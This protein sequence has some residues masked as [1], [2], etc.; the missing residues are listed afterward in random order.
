[1]EEANHRRK[2]T[3]AREG[4]VYNRAEHAAFVAILIKQFGQEYFE[5]VKGWGLAT[6][7]PVFVF[8]LPR[9][10]STLLEQ[11][12][13]SHPQVYGAGELALGKEAFDQVTRLLRCTELT[14][15]HMSLIS[16]ADVQQIA[17]AHLQ[18]LRRFSAG[19]MRIVDKMPDNY[20]WL[21]FLA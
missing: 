10:G 3:W 13:A 2:E 4:K 12:L 6:E 8:G 19:A 20:L 5:R 9:S 1:A 11:I 16:Q 7:V 21:G 14:S 18:Q 15:V 17:E